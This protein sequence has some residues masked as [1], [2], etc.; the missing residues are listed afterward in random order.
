MNWTSRLFCILLLLPLTH[1]LFFLL[2]FLEY[3]PKKQLN[4]VND[5]KRWGK[6]RTAMVFNNQVVTLKFP[7]YVCVSLNNLKSVTG[8]GGES[9][10]H[11]FTTVQVLKYVNMFVI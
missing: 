4:V 3:L 7:E 9:E 1:V 2:H 11:L 10:R 6:R 8:A 5:D